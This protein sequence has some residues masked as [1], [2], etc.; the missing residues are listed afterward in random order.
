MYLLTIR[1]FFIC[2]YVCIVALIHEIHLFIC[3]GHDYLHRASLVLP[4]G[5]WKTL[6][7]PKYIRA[8]ISNVRY[9]K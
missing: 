1:L 9:E 8:G 5:R 2:V 7:A 3:K 4:R 6:R